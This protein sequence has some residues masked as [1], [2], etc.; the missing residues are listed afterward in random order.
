M[1]KS[2]IVVGAAAVIL[3]GC[4]GNGYYNNGYPPGY[5]PPN[6]CHVPKNV[7]LVYPAANATSVPDNVST[8]YLSLPTA[9]SKPA[10]FNL[11]LVPSSSSSIFTGG[12]SQVSYG[13]IPTPNSTPSYSNPIYYGS[14]INTVLAPAS[15][16]SVYWNNANSNCVQGPS[17]FLGSFDTQ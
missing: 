12:F 11:V 9:L 4:Y 10:G 7:H 17:N 16:Y 13:S 15:G 3:A 5:G 14:A 8:I 2:W 6:P 1:R